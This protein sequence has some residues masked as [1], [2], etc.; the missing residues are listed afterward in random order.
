M[1]QCTIPE[2]ARI[3]ERS[4]TRRRLLGAAGEIAVLAYQ[5][6]DDVEEVVDRAEQLLF[7]VS[8]RRVARELVPV[9]QVL[10]EYYDRIEYLT[11]HRGEMIGIPTGFL[12]RL[13]ALRVP[14]VLGGYKLDELETPVS[15][16]VYR[17]SSM[18]EL[19]ALLKG[20]RLTPRVRS[21]A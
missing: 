5:E 20:M 8:E 3:V 18:A 16:L 11:R 14:L 15:D 17:G 6:A 1:L 4:S 19:E 10:S 21:E 13:S 7:G 12:E 2:H 9:K